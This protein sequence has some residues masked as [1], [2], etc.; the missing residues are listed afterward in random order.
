MVLSLCARQG[1]SSE[2]HR[3]RIRVFHYL[4]NAPSVGIF[5]TY[6]A[7]LL[8]IAYIARVHI[9]EKCALFDRQAIMLLN[10]S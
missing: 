6:T 2:E 10:D 8:A 3:G 4:H 5:F 9:S 7:N 1:R